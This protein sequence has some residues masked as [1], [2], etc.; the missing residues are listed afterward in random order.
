M[1][2]LRADGVKVD[3]NALIRGLKEKIPHGMIS[4]GGH[5]VAGAMRFV[6]GVEDEVQE[7]VVKKI[8]D[9]NK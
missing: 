7:Y 5:P 9:D 1:I 8:I 4:G 6:E 2:T 3:V